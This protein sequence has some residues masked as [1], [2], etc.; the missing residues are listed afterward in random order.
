MRNPVGQTFLRQFRVD[1][2]VAS[3][4]MGAIYK[5]W[6][7]KRNVYL[8]MKILHADLAD[9]P[10][11]LKRFRREARA[12]KKLAHPNIV[13]FYGLYETPEYKFFLEAYIDGCSLKEI[14]VSKQ[15]QPFTVT[16]TLTYLKA[17]CAALGYAHSYGVIHCD[18]KPGNVM[19]DASGKVYLTDF[20]IARHAESTF[21]T[22]AT[23]GTAAYM[24][25]EQIRGDPVS[26]TTDVYALGVLMFEMLTGRHPFRGD[27]KEKSGTGTT[28]AEK[29]RSAHLN[30]QPPNPARF[31]PLLS[32][33]LC[34]V[35]LKALTKEPD[36]RYSSVLDLYAA[37]LQS[38][39]GAQQFVSDHVPVP[40]S[41]KFQATSE[42]APLED[43]KHKLKRRTAWTV[44][45]IVLLVAITSFASMK[46]FSRGIG[47]DLVRSSLTVTPFEELVIDQQ[48]KE[49]AALT[50]D[51]ILAQ[52]MLTKT[53]GVDSPSTK[54]V[55][56]SPTALPTKEIAFPT[57]IPAVQ[58][59]FQVIPT[60]FPLSGCNGSRLQVGG[61]AYI[62]FGGGRNA[63]RSQPDVGDKNN[64]IGFA[65]EGEV[66]NI[67]GGP[68]CSYNW[69]VWEVQ[70]SQG[71]RGWTPE[72]DEREFWLVPGTSWKP[73][74]QAPASRLQAGQ[75]ARVSQYPDVPN[76]VRQ[77]PSQDAKK[78]GQI[79]PGETIKIR[80]G[81]VCANSMVWWRVRSQSSSLAGWTAEGDAHNY[82]LVPI[83]EAE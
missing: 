43:P 25:P 37:A 70:T 19:I 83:P 74:S 61:W 76:N 35:V 55:G 72:G 13:P 81:P 42:E 6:D 23:A 68:I 11:I 24:A 28:T 66:V 36:Q 52:T 77:N 30:L 75:L 71:V 22:L 79:M 5:V 49:S 26:T 54:T 20:G 48:A 56:P 51:H 82:W 4:G 14:L 69:V 10:S 57:P 80:E 64:K 2:F 60:Y 59:S 41:I 29:I 31:N 63:I 16:E 73:C 33:E 62:A 53:P 45:V 65:E 8:A 58:N 47:S 40:N 15:R 44:S 27:E 34:Q 50:P 67:I 1:A 3:G 38:L 32:P 12:L 78:L 9:E 46:A 39:Q 17:L 21:T 7:Q 18:V